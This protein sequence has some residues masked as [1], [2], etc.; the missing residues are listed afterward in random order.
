MAHK[1]E[2]EQFFKISLVKSSARKLNEIEIAVFS[3]ILKIEKIISITLGFPKFSKDLP[4]FIVWESENRLFRIYVH[5][6]LGK[7]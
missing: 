6:K 2:F 7:Y 3:S 1:L 5:L 4:E